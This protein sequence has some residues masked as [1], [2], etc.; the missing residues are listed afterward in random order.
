MENGPSSRRCGRAR[1][2]LAGPGTN[3]EVNSGSGF[4]PNGDVCAVGEGSTVHTMGT[5]DVRFY[6]PSCGGSAQALL[7]D[8]TIDEQSEPV[9]TTVEKYRCPENCNL[10]DDVVVAAAEAGG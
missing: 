7:N 5:R 6:C 4:I 8:I 10:S 2:R 1:R 9:R 3:R